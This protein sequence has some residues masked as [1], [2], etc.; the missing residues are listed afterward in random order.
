MNL[1]AKD[2]L[3]YGG[4]WLSA[5]G[6]IS[7]VVVALWMARRRRVGR[8]RLSIRHI[9]RHLPAVRTDYIRMQVVNTGE[10]PVTITG[11]GWRIGFPLHRKYFEQVPDVGS[12]ALPI[13]LRT[14][15]QAV[16][17]VPVVGEPQSWAD[18]LASEFEGGRARLWRW[19][20]ARF[21]R[22]IAYTA[23]EGQVFAALPIPL[24]TLLADRAKLSRQQI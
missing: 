21:A 24:R 12:D 6:S 23:D 2:I 8:P 19:L 14:G 13:E 7:A 5:I 11:I 22:G 3:Q 16:F 10:A 15:Q 20:W 18:A 9:T 17:F 1:T 4:P